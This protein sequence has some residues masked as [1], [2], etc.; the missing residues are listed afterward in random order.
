[1]W[2]H[3]LAHTH[4]Q[5]I[6]N[7]QFHNMALGLPKAHL[8]NLKI[9][10]GCILG[11]MPQHPFTPRQTTSSQPLQLVHNDLCGPF[12]TKSIS[13]SIYFISFIEDYSKFTIITFLKT[14]NQALSAFKIY[15][16]LAENLTNH[17]LKGIPLK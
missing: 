6:K 1:M 10:E 2:H 5:A 7:M 4:L 15:L 3:R 9:F 17:K 14:K 16:P 12:P 11:K 13:G 8:T